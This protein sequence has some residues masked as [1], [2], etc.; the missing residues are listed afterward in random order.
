MAD[1]FSGNA[2]ST[3]VLAIGTP[4]SG[5]IDMAGDL[6]WFRVALTAGQYY[7]IT[8][9]GA[10]G[11]YAVSAAIVASDDRPGIAG[12]PAGV[13]DWLKALDGG[14]SRAATLA[15]F[16]EGFENVAAVAEVIGSGFVY[17]PYGG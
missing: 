10:A 7:A 15:N 11:A 5:N 9:T 1:D 13:D 16:S 4:S 6:D 14:Y 8:A 2:N 17:L 12:E 3:G